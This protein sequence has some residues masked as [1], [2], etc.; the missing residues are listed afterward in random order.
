LIAVLAEAHEQLGNAVAELSPGQINTA[1]AVKKAVVLLHASMH[2]KYAFIVQTARAVI[3][4]LFV[5]A[6]TTRPLHA[7]LQPFLRSAAAAAAT[8]LASMH[9]FF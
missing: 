9:P 6:E 3:S 1:M 7:L 8:T 4:I 2:D 5:F